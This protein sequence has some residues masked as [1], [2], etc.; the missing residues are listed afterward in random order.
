[1]IHCASSQ[2]VDSA[3]AL[4]QGLDERKASTGRDVFFVHVCGVIA[5]FVRVVNIDTVY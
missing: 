5:L 1:M 3:V 4:V 2:D